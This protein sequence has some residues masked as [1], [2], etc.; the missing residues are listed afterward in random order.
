MKCLQGINFLQITFAENTKIKNL[1]RE[2]PDSYSVVVKTNKTQ[3]RKFNPPIYSKHKWLSGSAGRK[4][5]L[6]LLINNFKILAPPY[7]K[8]VS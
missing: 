3:M 4:A 6:S 7:H 5:L 1:D 8:T 2:T